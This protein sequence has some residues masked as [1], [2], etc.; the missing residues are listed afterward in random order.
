[1]ASQP[2]SQPVSQGADQPVSNGASATSPPVV[3]ADRVLPPAPR[4]PEPLVSA[5]L[6]PAAIVTLNERLDLLVRLGAARDGG[7]LS[8]EEFGREKS[9]LLGV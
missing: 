4:E 6:T 8:E 9:R 2:V 5:A 3:V 7:I 1:L